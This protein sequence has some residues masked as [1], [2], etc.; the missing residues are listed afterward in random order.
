MSIPATLIL[1][2]LLVLGPTSAF[3]P[4]IRI[5]SDR[6]AHY[7]NRRHDDQLYC[8][9]W[10]LL[11]EA[12]NSVAWTEPLKRCADYVVKYSR[13]SSTVRTWRCTLPRRRRMPAPCRSPETE[14]T[15]GC[16]TST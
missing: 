9:S 4:L 14:R 1:L 8:N 2:L 5:P 16:S 6:R 11:V 3:R 7:H 15:L 13:G 10:R 12:N